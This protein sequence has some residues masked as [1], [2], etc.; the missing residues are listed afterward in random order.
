MGTCCIF[1]Y[2]AVV[3]QQRVYMPHCSLL[4]AICPEY[5]TGVLPFL[6]WGVCFW[7]LL[8][9][10]AFFPV[11]LFARRLT[12]TAPT[13]PSSRPLIPSASP[14]TCDPV[15]LYHHHSRCR[16]PLDPVYHIIY[17]GDCLVWALP[18]GLAFGRFPVRVVSA[19]E[20]SFVA[21]VVA[22]TVGQSFSTSFHL[23]SGK[24]Q[25]LAGIVFFSFLGWGETESTWYVGHWLAY[26]TS[27]GW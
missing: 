5:P 14:I 20:P 2:L 21:H 24:R 13:T 12:P 15:H 22:H 7:R 26:C 9:A 1:A 3:S 25:V 6:F 4:K 8:S 18:E 10:L 19:M 23:V 11:A 27:T 16:I 17:L